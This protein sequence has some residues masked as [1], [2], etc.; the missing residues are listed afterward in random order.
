MALLTGYEC[1]YAV[2]VD[3][4]SGD[5]TTQATTNTHIYTSITM[6]PAERH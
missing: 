6:T 4:V 5:V 3:V 2:N 1:D